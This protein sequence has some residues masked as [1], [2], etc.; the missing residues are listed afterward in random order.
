MQ[1]TSILAPLVNRST[2]R[3]T[4][5]RTGPPESMAGRP[6]RQHGGQTLTV[7]TIRSHPE[8]DW[9]R[10]K[11]RQ[12]TLGVSTFLAGVNG[13]ARLMVRLSARQH[14]GQARQTA[15]RTGPPE[16][17]AGRPARQHGGQALTLHVSPSRF[18]H[19]SHFLLSSSPLPRY[20][21]RRSIH[22]RTCSTCFCS[23]C[24]TRRR[25]CGGR[26]CSTRGRASS[27]PLPV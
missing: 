18:N 1:A 6:A 8:P 9:R 7:T 14:G 3:Q 19:A 5:W 11:L 26:S 27:S 24:N 10:G 12:G 22:I 20:R 25:L 17:M 21:P 13:S 15:W 16:S 4:A 23:T 2:F